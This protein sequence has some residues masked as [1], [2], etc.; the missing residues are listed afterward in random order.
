MLLGVWGF[1]S[2]AEAHEP[3][4]AWLHGGVVPID[5]DCPVVL[6]AKG[7][8]D[9]VVTSVAIV[10]IFICVSAAVRVFTPV[11]VL[12]IPLPLARGPPS[13]ADLRTA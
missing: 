10:A 3:L 8:I 12:P 4:H 1:L 9:L 5:D 13:W 7:K 11:F 6:L 2:A